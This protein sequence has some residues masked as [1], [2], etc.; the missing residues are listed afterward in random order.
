MSTGKASGKAVCPQG[1]SRSPP[2]PLHDDANRQSPKSVYKF[3]TTDEATTALSTSPALY[4]VHKVLLRATNGAFPALKCRATS[5]SG[6]MWLGAPTC[7]GLGRGASFW[8]FLPEFALFSPH[9]ASKMRP[10][11]GPYHVT[12]SFVC[13][14]RF[15]SGFHSAPGPMSPITGRPEFGR[16]TS[17][18]TGW[19]RHRESRA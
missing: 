12:T 9:F 16:G 11:V 6:S 10:G 8:R 5:P 13:S 18:G 3:R 7:W 2:K 19:G 17:R 14:F 1:D 15:G 4:M